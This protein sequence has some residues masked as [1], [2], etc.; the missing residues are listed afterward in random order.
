MNK[1]LSKILFALFFIL[2]LGKGP[3]PYALGMV[4]GAFTP[5]WII[6]LIISIIKSNR[7]KTEF[8]WISNNYLLIIPLIIFLFGLFGRY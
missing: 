1:H 5:Y 6:I 8:K 3:F 4:I 7:N 2:A